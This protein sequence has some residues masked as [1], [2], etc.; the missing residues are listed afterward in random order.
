MNFD[1][2]SLLLI[3]SMEVEEN[4]NSNSSLSAA[5]TFE[6]D[7]DKAYV[8]EAG[9]VSS[10]EASSFQPPPDGGYG[11]IVSFASCI[12][13]FFSLGNAFIFA[14]LL[15]TFVEAF[16]APHG[17]TAWIGS[18]CGGIMTGSGIVVGA[19][20]DYY[21]N[22]KIIFI[23]AIAIFSGFMLASYSTELW[24]LYLL[25]GVIAGMGMSCVFISAIGVTGPWFTTKRALALGI[26]FSGSGLGQLCLSF[27]ANALI[28]VY[29]WRGCLRGLAVIEGVSI[30]IASYFIKRYPP[31]TPTVS[32]NAS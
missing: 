22:E 7:G 24:H 4:C 17:T 19:L 5:S 27:T 11:W 31:L 6:E 14:V 28:R 21:G 8:I 10:N 26:A 3:F 29:S 9:S 32:I 15:P 2:H 18:I 13:M 30:L 20:A 12:A 16:D 23:G 25:Y 1:R